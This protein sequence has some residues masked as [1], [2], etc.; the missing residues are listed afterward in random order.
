MIE[1]YKVYINDN[2]CAFE[3]ISDALDMIECEL[4]ESDVV[5][6]EKTMM[7]RKQFEELPEFEG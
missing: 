2:W 7:S 6:I 1:I 5:T 4:E 3:K